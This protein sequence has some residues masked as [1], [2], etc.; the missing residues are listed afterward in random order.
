VLRYMAPEF[1]AIHPVEHR[2]AEEEI[3][4]LDMSFLSTVPEAT[5]LVP[6]YSA[7]LERQDQEP[8]YRT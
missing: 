4:L 7:W 8:A 5:M 1:F 2:C 6:E 3:L